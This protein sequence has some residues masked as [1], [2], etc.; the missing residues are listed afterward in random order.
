MRDDPKIER[1]MR[2]GERY[3]EF[4]APICANCGEE[5]PLMEWKIEI[6]YGFGGLAEG[7]V[8]EECFGEWLDELTISEVAD[9][10]GLTVKGN[11]G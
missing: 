10:M 4:Q 7:W 3:S 2:T 9:Y 8:C 1:L 11:W 5:I 6:P